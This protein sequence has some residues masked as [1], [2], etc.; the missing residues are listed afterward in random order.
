M[1]YY[2]EILS[3]GELYALA[4]TE[5]PRTSTERIEFREISKTYYEWLSAHG[6]WWTPQKGTENE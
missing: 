5:E 3:E 4:I 6:P 2:Y 1:K